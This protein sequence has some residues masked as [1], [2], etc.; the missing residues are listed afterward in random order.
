VSCLESKGLAMS[1]FY[2]DRQTPGPKGNPALSVMS[3]AN[4]GRERQLLV[5]SPDGRS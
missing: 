1:Q 3:A 2:R 4:N 5:S